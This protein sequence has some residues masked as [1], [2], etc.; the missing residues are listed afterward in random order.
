MNTYTYKPTNLV[1]DENGIVRAVD[2]TVEVSDGVDTFEINGHT[3]LPLPK[4]MIVPYQDL[5]QNEVI[6]W[7]KNLVG[8]QT[9]EQADAE[10][11]AYK[12]RLIVKNGT[13]WSNN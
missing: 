6:G 8:E 12:I 5:T 7:I 11:E 13:P 4:D 3:G 10:L 9:E 1:S 2:F